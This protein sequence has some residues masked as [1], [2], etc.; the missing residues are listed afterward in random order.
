MVW[1]LTMNTRTDYCTWYQVICRMF[2]AGQA[3]ATAYVAL[4]YPDSFIC[5][6]KKSMGRYHEALMWGVL[7]VSLVM[8]LESLWVRFNMLKFRH[9]LFVFIAF[10][11]TLVGYSVF[12]VI[13]PS[14]LAKLMSVYNLVF[15]LAISLVDAFERRIERLN[16]FRNQTFNELAR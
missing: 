13:E 4:F 12:T 5:S 1:N 8:M 10:Y 9:L 15:C 11:W 2:V 14:P 16:E 3:F 7:A 6:V